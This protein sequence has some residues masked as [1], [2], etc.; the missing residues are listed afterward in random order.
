MAETAS[1]PVAGLLLCS[2]LMWISKVTGTAQALG[3]K[4]VAAANVTKLE[5][6]AGKLQPQCVILDLSAGNGNWADLVLR[7]RA[8]AS[9]INRFVAYGSHVDVATLEAARAAGCDPVLPRSKM[10]EGLPVF[11]REWL[12][13]TPSTPARS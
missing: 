13:P 10:A 2:D 8:A 12:F 4:V 1:P 9:S 5:E 6:L 3:L 11:L 7:L